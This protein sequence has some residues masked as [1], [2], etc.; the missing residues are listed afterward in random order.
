MSDRLPSTSIRAVKGFVV[1]AIVLLIPTM[2]YFQK[3]RF[4]NRLQP[5][6]RASVMEILKA[7]GVE[8]PSVRMDYLDAVITGQA[9]TEA[10]RRA[11]AAK[12]NA[13]PGVRVPRGGNN[14]HTYGWIRISRRNDRYRGEGVISNDLPTQLPES[15]MPQVGWDEEM[16]RRTMVEVPEGLP[17]WREFL[18]Y[19]F[20]GTGNRSVE[21]RVSVLTMRGDATAGLRSDWLSKASE[22]V[23]KDHVIDEFTLSPSIYHFPG[24]HPGSI[25]GE[26]KVEQLRRQF[27]ENVVSFEAG[28]AEVP[29]AE[30]SKAVAAARA[31]L[32]AGESGRYV[33]GGHPGSSGNVTANGKLARQRARAVVRLLVEYGVMAEQLDV[34]SFG[35]TPDDG[36]DNQVEIMV[37]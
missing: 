37:K 33:V 20:S 5:Q 6:L 34:V 30:R 35:V 21:L 27:A 12:V 22:V 8:A 10:R 7:E 14:L 1:L 24:H 32:N 29:E 19:Y 36:R 13:L 31:I 25:H 11:V 28:S 15:L 2:G 18:R 16:A 4:V 17:E 26:T 3:Q 23:A 9:G